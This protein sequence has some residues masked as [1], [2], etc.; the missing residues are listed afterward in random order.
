MSD[1]SADMVIVPLN[2]CSQLEIDG[3]YYDR[4]N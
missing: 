2:D 3:V 1:A 4:Q